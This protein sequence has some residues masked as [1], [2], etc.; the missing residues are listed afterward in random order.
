MI[1]LKDKVL[2]FPAALGKTMSE[3]FNLA[4]HLP[5]AP[6]ATLLFAI[7]N[8]NPEWTPCQRH[9]LSAATLFTD[10]IGVG[11]PSRAASFRR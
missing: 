6:Q 8:K 4:D 10:S 1:E 5:V 3:Q 7:F 11:A 2:S 9:S